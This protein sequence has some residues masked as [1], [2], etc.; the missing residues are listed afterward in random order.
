MI[1]A[2]V[3]PGPA[4]S[5]PTTA[6]MV[7]RAVY[8]RRWSLLLPAVVPFVVISAWLRVAAGELPFAN[9]LILTVLACYL[10]AW[11]V[12]KVV[13]LRWTR[14]RGRLAVE[15]WQPVAAVVLRR[16]TGLRRTVLDVGLGRP[17]AVRLP[18]GH[19]EAVVR[20]GRAWL[21]AGPRVLMV[22]ADGSHRVFAAN[23]TELVAAAAVE[24]VDADPFTPAVL[25]ARAMRRSTALLVSVAASWSAAYVLIWWEI[26]RP[27]YALVLTATPLVLIWM[28]PL[29]MVALPAWRAV[30]R[31][32]SGPWTWVSAVMDPWKA[33]TD[34]PTR[35]SGKATL[36]DGTRLVVKLPAAPA[37]FLGA[38]WETGGFWVA[39][40]PE[41]GRVLAA[42]F[43]H[44]P[45]AAAVRFRPL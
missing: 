38:V 9:A 13:T 17:V 12:G 42:G 2:P 26:G 16:A 31:P 27:W 18:A 21:V 19:E 23:A 33:H 34:A 14:G 40:T 28:A 4:L 15:P 36:A 25:A 30:A 20:T 29:L 32:A 43:P 39:G 35:A 6:L 11:C 10:V 45:L 41:P 22:R 37:D 1:P 5:D 7:A 8:M 44:A 3:L 24:P